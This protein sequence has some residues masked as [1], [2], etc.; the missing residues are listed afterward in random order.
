[1]HAAA[2]D[3]VR[4]IAGPLVERGIARLEWREPE[5]PDLDPAVELIPANGT[6]A[7]VNV[8]PGPCLVTP[9]VGLVAIRM[10]SWSI[11][12]PNGSANC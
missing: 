4:D 1:V 11:A 2:F 6:A 10:K 9:L 12:T 5:H 3:V 7:P 8:T